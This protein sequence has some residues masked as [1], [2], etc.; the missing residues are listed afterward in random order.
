ML[1]NILTC[2][3]STFQ[4]DYIEKDLLFKKQIVGNENNT[5]AGFINQL[6][7]SDWIKAGLK[8]LPES[9][10]PTSLKNALFAKSR[11]FQSN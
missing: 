9:S 4:A 5:V 8:Y 6:G 1:R 2:L 7:N 10:A 3:K 11:P